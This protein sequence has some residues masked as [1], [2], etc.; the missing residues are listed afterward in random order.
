MGEYRSNLKYPFFLFIFLF[1]RNILIEKIDFSK[2]GGTFCMLLGELL[3]G[4]IVKLHKECFIKKKKCR[5]NCK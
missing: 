2:E 5:K 1:T 3:T 4:I